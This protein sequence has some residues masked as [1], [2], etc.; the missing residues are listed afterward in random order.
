MF[1]A[2]LDNKRSSKPSIPITCL[3]LVLRR[4]KIPYFKFIFA[5]PGHREPSAYAA[6]CTTSPTYP[7]CGRVCYKTRIGALQNFWKSVSLKESH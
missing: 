5:A 7:A 1:S 3:G 2:R 4:T 6:C